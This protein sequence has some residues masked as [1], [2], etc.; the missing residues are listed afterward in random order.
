MIGRRQFMEITSAGALNLVSG[1]IGSLLS[2]PSAFAE[3]KSGSNFNPDLD[4]SLTAQPNQIPIFP[5][6]DT[7]VWSFKGQVLKGSKTSLI[8]LKQSY[9]G[10]TILARKG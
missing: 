7:R 8:N 3:A 2:L 6:T 9:L 5:G 4:I 1:G 10:P